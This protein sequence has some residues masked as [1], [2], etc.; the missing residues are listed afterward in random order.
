[1][2]PS[3]A[4]GKISRPG[5]RNATLMNLLGTP[6]LGS[7]MAGRRLAGI[8]QLGMFL[9]GFIL[10]CLWV[11]PTIA[12]YYRLAD[13]ETTPPPV[14]GG[15]R[16]ALGVGLC[17]FSWCWSLMTSL[18]LMRDVSQVKVETLKSFAA[19]QIKI[20]PAQIPSAL[21]TIPQWQHHD[22]VISRTYEF[23]NFPAAMN[24][25]NAVGRIAEEVQHHPDIDIRW[26]KVT[27]ALTTHDA[28]GLTEKGLCPGPTVRHIV[29]PLTLACVPVAVRLKYRGH[30]LLEDSYLVRHFFRFRQFHQP[31][32]RFFQG[33]KRQLKGSVMH[34]HK[35][36]CP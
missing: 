19:G 31:T 23:K 9:A 5:A 36:L 11:F 29:T 27:L 24:F 28:G 16:A 21:I 3:L 7:I 6:G 1:M 32:R 8:G 12:S 2:K 33:F 14:P 18:S 20:D 34:R 4:P 10:F 17:I 15:G 30:S 35:Y 22:P 25:I 26:N 13:F